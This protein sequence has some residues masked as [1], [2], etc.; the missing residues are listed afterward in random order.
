MLRL[1]LS[2]VSEHKV[3]V[4]DLKRELRQYGVSGFVAHEDIA[5]SLE[6]QAEIEVALQS[7]DAMAAL[8]TQEFHASSWTDQEVGVAIGRG[9]LVIPIRLPVIPYG[10][11]AKN[12]A[13][14]GDLSKPAPLA[15]SLVDILLARPRTAAAIRE[16]LVAALET[17]SSWA[18]SKVVATKIEAVDRFTAEHIARIEAAIVANDEVRDSFGV[19]EKL[20]RVIAKSASGG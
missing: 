11:I 14:R 13:L 4:S 3:A 9:V 6:W 7:M 10:F 15:S 17:S 20:R 2:H 18:S 12:Q 16:A 5:P 19:P 1:F 8:L